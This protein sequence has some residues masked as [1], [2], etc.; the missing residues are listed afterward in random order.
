M[1]ASEEITLWGRRIHGP[2]LPGQG[3]PCQR[4]T[5]LTVAELVEVVEIIARG[6]TERHSVALPERLIHIRSRKNFLE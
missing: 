5:P 6:R 4:E 1:T 3:V 2:T